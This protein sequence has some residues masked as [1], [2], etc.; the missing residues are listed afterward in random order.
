MHPAR[1][2]IDR[3][4]ALLRPHPHRG[5]I[6]AAGAVPLTVALLLIDVRFAGKWNDG[7]LLA[8]MGL[9]AAL[10]LGMG[11]LARMEEEAPRAYQSALFLSG[12]ALA[13]AAILRLAD[14][15]GASGAD[16]A[17]GTV[18]WMGTMF[19]AIA[20]V[21]ALRRNS[22]IC[23]FVAALAGV[24]VAIAF[25]DWVFAP[26]STATFRW[27]LLVVIIA[28]GLAFTALRDHRRRHAVA[29][30]NAAG[31]AT[32]ALA[33]TFAL[34]TTVGPL[35]GGGGASAGT[36]WE[37]V[38][39]AMG[40]ALVAYAGVDREP[41]PGYLGVAILAAFL[42][43]TGPAAF[44]GPSLIGWPLLLLLAGAAM[45]VIGLRPIEPLPPE[46][47][48]VDEPDTSAGLPTESLRP[49]DD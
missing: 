8:I 48:P 16:P 40:F 11:L 2:A 14:V 15:L 9:A 3:A 38:I 35:Q 28:Y 41:G 27:I 5:D 21:P 31:L 7:V 34:R 32:L 12:L 18:V 30:L 23:A 17:S 20:L 29:L 42:V 47:E 26:D 45:L 1:P 24:I 43:V 37:L 46:P 36:G 44:D 10:M 6:I 25:V 49:V 19:A 4:A 13:A 33:A 39:A 22:A